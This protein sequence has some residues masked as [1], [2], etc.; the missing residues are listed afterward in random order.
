MRQD[1]AVSASFFAA[2]SE[3]K[4]PDEG[5]TLFLKP[6]RS[7]IERI[8]TH[9]TLQG[10]PLFTRSF[11][12]MGK[13]SVMSPQQIGQV[14]YL[15]IMDHRGFRLTETCVFLCMFHGLLR[16]FNVLGL[17]GRGSR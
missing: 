15:K 9:E 10:A 11:G 13:I 6:E 8:L 1:D 4:G 3:N 7:W 17:K 2:V 14:T 12:R 5:E 16:Q